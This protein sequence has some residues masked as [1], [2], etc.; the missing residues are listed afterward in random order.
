MKVNR[1]L[2]NNLAVVGVGWS[3]R[4]RTAGFVG[5]QWAE[6]QPHLLSGA[7]APVVSTVLSLERAAEALELL[8]QRRAIGK[9][10]LTVGSE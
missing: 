6:L 7:L 5:H 9:V 10:A 4:F 1:L 3:E 8:E 2:L